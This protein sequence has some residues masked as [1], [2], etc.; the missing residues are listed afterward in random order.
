MSDHF[1][2]DPAVRRDETVRS[3]VAD[4]HLAPHVEHADVL[5]RVVILEWL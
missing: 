1:G 2:A 4:L 5:G 3:Y